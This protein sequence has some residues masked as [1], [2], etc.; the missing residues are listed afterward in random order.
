MPFVAYRDDNVT[1]GRCFTTRDYSALEKEILAEKDRMTRY[2]ELDG[3]VFGYQIARNNPVS[4]VYDME[5]RV[6]RFLFSRADTL[7][8]E[9]QEEVMA[10]LLHHLKEQMEAEPAYYNLRLPCHFTDLTRAFNRELRSCP[11]MYFCGGTTEQIHV[12]DIVPIRMDPAVRLFWASPEYI[13]ANREP[14]LQIMYDSFELYQGQYHI[15]PVTA[16]RA[17]EIYRNWVYGAFTDYE[18]ETVIAAEYEGRPVGECLLRKTE[19]GV[20]GLLCSIDP[21]V[22]RLGI[23]RGILDYMIRF[24]H[25]TGRIFVASTQMDN[26]ISCGTMNSLNMRPLYGIY[27]FHNDTRRR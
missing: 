7:H 17:G 18:P 11:G 3:Q 9:E 16:P 14:M 6:V 26:F 24:A 13:A 10:R 23:Y 22:R 27:N 15:S 12:G 20:D 25:D 2:E 1:L 5:V 19:Q 8:R 4:R 21:A